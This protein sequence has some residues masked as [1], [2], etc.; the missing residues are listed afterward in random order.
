MPSRLVT[1]HVYA[2]KHC[3]LAKPLVRESS[4]HVSTDDGRLSILGATGPS[5]LE[6]IQEALLQGYAVQALARSPDKIA[7]ANDKL[8]VERV[9]IFK[10]DDLAKR[11]RGSSAVLSCLGAR[12][13]LFSHQPCTLYS[14][15]MKTVAAAMT[16]AGVHRFVCVDSWCTTYTPGSPKVIE[17]FSRPL[18]LGN[19]LSD[20]AAMED[21]ARHHC[22]NINYTFVRA[23]GL[24]TGPSTG[25][26]VKATEGQY[27]KGVALS[28]PRRDVVK[29]MLSTLKTQEWDR[30][31]VAIGI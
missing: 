16:A 18:F 6:L 24:S 4:S 3:C 29:F 30:K 21:Y 5:G 10:P 27:I 22:S 20:M 1:R 15:S 7:L 19:V 31:C 13:S 17:W 8:T 23:P 9:N 28:M 14:H 25:K 11:L 12:A 2:I 26:R